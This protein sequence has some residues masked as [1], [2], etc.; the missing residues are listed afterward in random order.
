MK[1]IILFIFVS[2]SFLHSFGQGAKETPFV[3]GEVLI[4][5]QKGY[6]IDHVINAFPSAVKMRVI[7]NLSTH[8]RFYHLGF[9]HS[10]MSNE[11]VLSKLRMSNA[12]RIAQNNHYIQERST[13]P[14]D[15]S[16]GSQWHH[17]NTTGTPDAD[18]DSDEAWDITTGGLTAHG[19]SIVVCVV[20]G[21]GA[22]W[23]HV[24]ILPNFWRNYGEIDGNSTDDDGNGYIDDI[25]GWNV[26]A[27]NDNH[28]NGSHGTQC[29][30]MVGA[31]GNNTTGVVGA[32]WDV[33][34]MLV[35]GFGV[36]ES[37]VIAAY[38]YPLKMRQLYNSTNGAKGAFVVATSSSWGI[39]AADPASYPL[40]CAYYDTLG[41]YGILN[42]GATTNSN[43]NVDAVGDMPT[44]CPSDYMISVT[45]TGN[46]DNQAGGYGLTTI[47]F[48]APGISV[49]TTSGT[50]SST[51]TSTTGTSFSCPL[52][53]GVIGLMYSVPCNSFMNMVKA[54]PQ[55]GA[56]YIR[57][58]LMNGVDPIPS[59]SGI[60]VTGGRL[61]A[62][63]AVNDI[64]TNCAADTCPAPYGLTVS[65]I[66]TTSAV[67]NWTDAGTSTGFYYYLRPVGST[68]WDSVNVTSTSVTLSS[69]LPCTEY[70]WMI[71]ATCSSGMSDYSGLFTF[72][73]DGCCTAP[74][75]LSASVLNDSSAT[76]S[77]GSVTAAVGYTI[78]IMNMADSTITTLAVTASPAVISGLDSC[79]Q[80]GIQVQTNC[81]SSSTSFS[82]M[83]YIVTGGCGVCETATYCASAGGSVADEYIDQVQINSINRISGADGGY[84]YTGLS[85]ELTQG[86][87]YSLTLS[88]GYTGTSYS[89]YFKAWIDFNQDGVF[90]DPTEKI[91]DS[92]SGVTSTVTG[93]VTIPAT[94]TP[95]VTRMRVAMKYISSG[96]I[97]QPSP[98]LAFAYGE[99]EDYC[100]EI[101]NGIGLTETPLSGNMVYMVYPNP[102]QHDLIF[103]IFNFEDLESS[104]NQISLVNNVGQTLISQP[105]QAKTT[106]VDISSLPNGVYSYTILIGNV[107]RSGKV[108][109]SR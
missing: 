22:N 40:W 53:A 79:T 86:L 67:L 98:C 23:N 80:Y 56:D 45:R 27:A 38:A 9:D 33:K 91:Y 26:N 66:T 18:I 92:G 65:G 1:K 88:P 87:S 46:T 41:V 34:I 63:N 89:E 42:V 57:A 82:P 6:S 5:L 83:V 16:F 49:Y 29:M 50:S 36:T 84:I 44:A 107:V 102:A 90:A 30:G 15:P 69:L 61:N 28:S 32:N 74:T 48:G 60:S 62:F 59:M 75:G 20:E 37:G 78:Q 97:A 77:F 7:S 47:D 103:T 51:Y 101:L 99:V 10:L 35:S 58:A 93:T 4:Q 72:T 52:T 76:V 55:G 100:V 68:A 70:E 11:L 3:N 8:M 21:G 95:G 43:L 25:N 2:F 39:D 13:I 17:L 108:I 94:A 31:K 71:G 85:T 81:A 73:T 106:T 54:D 105:L 12:V 19:D 109:V 14:N 96:D 64:L 24:D 104:N